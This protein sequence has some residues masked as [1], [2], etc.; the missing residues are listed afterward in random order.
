MGNVIARL[1]EFS[2][3][4]F[5]HGSDNDVFERVRVVTFAVW[6]L[7]KIRITAVIIMIQS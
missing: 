5:M 1:H 4:G 6:R 3:D 2:V 7:S